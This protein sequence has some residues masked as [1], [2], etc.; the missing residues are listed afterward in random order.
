MLRLAFQTAFL[1]LLAGC[2]SK[3][4]TPSTPPSP[5]GVT[6]RALENPVTLDPAYATRTFES[7]LACLIH[8]GLV[9]CGEDGSIV[10]ELA[11]SWEPLPEGKGYRFILREGLRFPSGRP[12]A[13]QDVVYAFSRIC[14]KATASPHAWVFED[15]AGAKEVRAGSAESI[16][17]I[18]SCGDSCVEIELEEPS[19]TL[20]ARLTMPAA[21][22]V[23]REEVETLGP[24]YG[25]HPLALGAWKLEEW[26]DDSRVTLKPNPSYPDRNR[27]LDFLRFTLA[28]QDFTANALFETGRLDVL[29]PLPLSQTERWKSFPAWARQIQR[30]PEMNVY[31]IGFGCHRPPFDRPGIR[32]ALLSAINPDRIRKALFGDL[33]VPA[34]GP[35]PPGLR[36]NPPPDPTTSEPDPVSLED[37]H[38]LSLDLW[39]IESDSTTSMA[40]EGVQADLAVSGV[41]CR[42]RKTDPTTYSSWRREGK[43][44]LFY[45]NWWADYPDPD[46]FVAP[47]FLSSSS[48]N[49]THFSDAETDRLILQAR[50]EVDPARRAHLY[51]QIED[52][53]ETLAPAC[54]L[55]HRGTEVLTQPWVK[56]YQPAPLF[57]G[58]LFLNLGISLVSAP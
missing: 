26:M 9:R 7:H 43:F 17:G 37:I 15:V 34:Q 30:F 2:S 32:R 24:S 27:N 46:N 50:R 53:I 25:R 12:L 20:L 35:I 6:I 18:R 52:R 36:G 47:L 39:Y 22:I 56:G 21:R 8:G 16:Q 23:D 55:W 14:R 41:Q 5:P 51:R 13:S 33:A 10:P 45:A 57:H 40:M 29:H 48:S 3:A 38:G 1:L 28:A 4:P 58:T 49:H 31:Y 19:A 44:D 42:L 11:S 54:F